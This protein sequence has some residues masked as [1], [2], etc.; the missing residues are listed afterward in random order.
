MGLRTDRRGARKSH[1]GPLAL[2]RPALSSSHETSNLGDLK[3]FP[4]LSL[5]CG[6][7]TLV[8]ASQG[9]NENSA[10]SPGTEAALLGRCPPLP[11]WHALSAGGGLSSPRLPPPPG[12]SNPLCGDLCG[13][14]GDSQ[15][16]NKKTCLGSRPWRSLSGWEAGTPTPKGGATPA[17]QGTKGFQSTPQ[18]LEYK[19]SC[20][21]LHL[22]FVRVVGEMPCHP[23]R[24]SP[25]SRASFRPWGG[26]GR[27]LAAGV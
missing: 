13:Q 22:T 5:I 7:E 9:L 16:E 1:A 21:P 12:L 19:V 8:P 24:T 18:Q 25:A 11:S 26:F 23:P 4:H 3:T 15:E 2:Q 10:S 27:L 6:V 17:S 14:R 20:G